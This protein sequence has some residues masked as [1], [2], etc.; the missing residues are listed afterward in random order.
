LQAAL[1]AMTSSSL[2]NT[3]V[4]SLLEADAQLFVDKHMRYMSNHLKMDHWQYI[5]NLKLMTK[6]SR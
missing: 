6:I 5:Q 3:H 1:L 2:Y 4:V